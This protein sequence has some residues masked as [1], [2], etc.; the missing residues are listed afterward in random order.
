MDSLCRWLLNS[1]GSRVGVILEGLNNL[2]L[3]YSLKSDFKA[4][5]NQVEYK[6]LVAGLQLAKEIG[7]LALNI[8]SNL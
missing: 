5:N 3:E 6:V 4:T 8:W 2:V 1:K 7:V